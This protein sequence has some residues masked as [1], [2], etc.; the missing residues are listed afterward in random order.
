MPILW[1][2]KLE[3]GRLS[4]FS[5]PG[6]CRDRT[7]IQVSCFLV[8]PR[9]LVSALC[10]PGWG[11]SLGALLFQWQTPEGSAAGV[12]FI[13]RLP[14]HAHSHAQPHMMLLLP[15]Q[16]FSGCRVLS[17]LTDQLS[18]VLE[19]THWKLSGSF[20]LADPEDVRLSSQLCCLPWL[21]R[22]LQHLPPASHRVCTGHFQAA[23]VVKWW[24][25]WRK[26]SCRSET[27]HFH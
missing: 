14:F 24:T 22:P 25:R 19:K 26:W 12:H 7:G 21:Q 20:S 13:L 1:T 15:C 9:P 27:Q 3:L 23:I 18:I 2:R 8:S 4:G 10:L 16:S 5:N 11:R 6:S 17:S